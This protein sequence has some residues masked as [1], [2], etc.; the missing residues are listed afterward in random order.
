MK[1]TRPHPRQ[2]TST[3]HAQL[4]GAM[5]LP[6]LLN[7]LPASA[8]PVAAPSALRFIAIGDTPYSDEESLVLRDQIA[9]AIRANPPAFVVH[10]GDFKNGKS[11]CSPALLTERRDQIYHLLP[12]KVF[13]TPGDNEWT[14]C[15]RT[16]LAHPVSELGSLDLIR[17]LFFSTPLDLPTSWGYARQANFPENASWTQE[18]VRFVSVHWVGTNN[19]RKQIKLD[20]ARL[21]LAMANAREQANRV[22]LDTAFQQ[23]TAEQARALVVLTHADISQQA[24]LAPCSPLLE[25]HC[26]AY[27][28]F[29]QQLIQRAHS[30]SS[31]KPVLLVHGDTSPYCW[32][33]QFGGATAPNLWRLNAWGDFQQPADATEI[34]V[35]TDN[36]TEPFSARTLVKH[37]KPAERC[38]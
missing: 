35:Q 6:L 1:L 15:D 19:G 13:Y 31:G 27:A 18:G 22:W 26:D 21:A 12:G 23:A 2:R 7:G 10:Y 3:R 34:T 33:K 29:R 37:I 17:R 24:G 4:I 28:E 20:D 11:D 5:V 36:Q 32:D 30:F 8:S 25:T 9:P 38:T 14:D 16:T